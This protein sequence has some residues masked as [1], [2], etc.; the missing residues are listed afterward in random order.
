MKKIV[1]YLLCL[2][3]LSGLSSITAFAASPTTVAVALD[4]ANNVTVTGICGLGSGYQVSILVTDPNGKQNYSNVI[5]SSSL[6]SYSVT[7]L[8]TNPVPGTYEVTANTLN[9]TPV[10]TT[11]SYG[12]DNSLSA[13]TVSNGGLDKAFASE[14]TAYSI[15]LENR[16]KS[17]N[18][19]PTIRNATSIVKVNNVIVVSGSPS[20]DIPLTEGKNTIT[21]TVTALNNVS[22]TYTLQVTRVEETQT[23]I[24]AT[25]LIESDKTV[26]L[27]GKLS[28]GAGQLVTAMVMDPNGKVDF[29]GHMISSGIGDFMLKYTLS[30]KA[31]GRYSVLVSAL[32]NKSSVMTSF[33]YF[34]M[35]GLTVTNVILSPVFENSVTTYTGTVSE[36]TA[37]IQITAIASDSTATIEISGQKA[38]SGAKVSNVLL[39]PGLNVIPVVLW[40]K[41]GVANKTYTLFITRG[42][43]LNVNGTCS[44]KLE[45]A[46]Y[47]NVSG[48]IGTVADLPLSIL[49]KD[50]T[51]K[52]EYMG[53]GKTTS[54]GS[55]NFN[56]LLANKNI[57][58]YSVQVGAIG[59]SVPLTTF[60]E[61][62]PSSTVLSSMNLTG[63]T[64]SPSFNK[65]KMN[66]T[67]TVSYSTSTLSLT[68][69]AVDPFATLTMNGN[70][71]ES[72]KAIRSIPLVEGSNKLEVCVTTQE[73][74]SRIY[75][76]IITK[77]SQPAVVDRPIVLSRNANL[78]DLSLSSG[79]LSPAFAAGTTSYTTSVTN[80]TDSISLTP[81]VANTN[82]SVKVNNVAVTSGTASGAIALAVG[83]NT[84]NIVVTAQNGST[85]T[86]T[87]TV[88]RESSN[89]ADLSGLEI[90]S[91]SLNPVFAE[92]TTSYAVSVGNDVNTI[93]VTPTV[94]DLTA[95]VEVNNTT[96]TSGTA[97][98]VIA[99]A[100]GDN[101]INIVVTA[102]N[103]SAKTYTVTLT[104]EADATLNGLTIQWTLAGNPVGPSLITFDKDTYSYEF[105]QSQN[106]SGM[107][108]GIYVVPVANDLQAL[109][110]IDV[111]GQPDNNPATIIPIPVSDFTISV[112]ITGVDSV[113][114][115]TYTIL[116]H[117]YDGS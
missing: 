7:Y 12:T 102:Q 63:A 86:Y 65:D 99:L 55:Y 71:I 62:L 64:I 66:Y 46:G 83:D 39:N 103:G 30:N 15:Q 31:N 92:G 84:I 47:V 101:T 24:T 23:T 95:T 51:G 82:A 4:G 3:L 80:G 54:E 5:T 76:I 48:K 69:I 57:G 78:S 77:E 34:E 110:E 21:V 44:A 112:H 75:T 72:G 85:K 43:E 111:A 88:T 13:L 17:I 20:S 22:K 61:K 70:A 29:L 87:V 36:T 50:S 56:Y 68:A 10:K 104:R 93:T 26:T 41:D 94:S 90:S 115:K 97:S 59:F 114:I 89:N 105:T 73:R 96:V 98:G 9:G 1:I 116:V 2:V 45:N 49:I 117:V 32:G 11:F 79:S 27:S 74:L 37:S 108:N 35:T 106:D 81:T 113:T 33:D 25:A 16:I 100:V 42:K 38:I 53:F 14:T 107:F 18:V 60:F 19:T 52:L 8:L 40:G 67:A 109:V 91:G 28:A 6:G 58:I